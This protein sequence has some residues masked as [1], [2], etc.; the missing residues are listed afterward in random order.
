MRWTLAIL[1][2]L[3]AAPAPPAVPPPPRGQE[4]RVPEDRVITDIRET[5]SGGIPEEW[6]RCVAVLGHCGIWSL[7]LADEK[8]SIHKIEILR[9]R[10]H[11]SP[12]ILTVERVDDP[13]LAAKWQEVDVAD[14][15]PEWG[16]VAGLSVQDDLWAIFLVDDAGDSAPTPKE[17][18][19]YEGAIRRV[20]GRG[21]ALA[22]APIQRYERSG[23]RNPDGRVIWATMPKRFG[24]L[25]GVL[26]ES[27]TKAR[28][29]SGVIGSFVFEVEK[30]EIRRAPILRSGESVRGWSLGR[31]GRPLTKRGQVS[32]V[33]LLSRVPRKTLSALEEAVVAQIPRHW[34]P[35]VA[36]ASE[37]P[38][39]W[40]M[41]LAAEDGTL[42]LISFSRGRPLARVP[43]LERRMPV[44]AYAE[45]LW[46]KGVYSDPVFPSGWGRALL[47]WGKAGTTAPGLGMVPFFEDD[48]GTIRFIYRHS[49]GDDPNPSFGQRWYQWDHEVR[50]L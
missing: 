10:G 42:R 12:K 9:G 14:I 37:D 15:P 7:V 39:A 49:V 30:G 5:F 43:V 21:A 19:Q 35:P 32:N 47:I 25:I 29:S 28:E 50:R 31:L 8:T 3:T 34:G 18:P 41:V 4:R 26:P 1:A 44:K 23:P 33:E 40:S 11:A 20:A 36:A 46:P 2:A 16:R 38:A 22:R 48:Q 17:R 24:N 6:G 13:D 45:K 27:S